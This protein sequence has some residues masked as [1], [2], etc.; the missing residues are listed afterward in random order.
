MKNEQMT[1]NGI[2]D[3]GKKMVVDAWGSRGES[4]FF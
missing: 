3:E 1:E 2:G 4:L